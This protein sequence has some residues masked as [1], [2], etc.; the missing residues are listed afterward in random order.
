MSDPARRGEL[1]GEETLA[2]LQP[3]ANFPL[4]R[5]LTERL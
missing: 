2:F 4:T 1:N 3:D 5:P